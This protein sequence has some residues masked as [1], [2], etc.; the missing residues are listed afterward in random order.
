MQIF[1]MRAITFLLILLTFTPG[2]TFG[3]NPNTWTRRADIGYNAINGPTDPVITFSIG[4]KGYLGGKY[5]DPS[6]PYDFW[7]FDTSTNLWTQKAS[8]GGA[9]KS[10]IVGFS[11]GQKGY[12]VGSSYNS[13]MWE[14]TPLTNTWSR[15]ANFPGGL[16]HNPAAFVIMDKAYVGLG[17]FTNFSTQWPRDFWEYNPQTDTWA[18]IDSFAGDGRSNA[19]TFSIINRGYVGLGQKGATGLKDFWEYDPGT[20]RWVRIPDFPADVR[21]E[22]ASFGIATDTAGYIIG[23]RWYGAS[24]ADVW[25]YNRNTNSWIKKNDYPGNLGNMICFVVGNSPF[26]GLRDGS[27]DLWQY[28]TKSDTWKQK[29]GVGGIKRTGP[30]S[31]SINGKGYI[32]GGNPGTIYL[33]NDFWEYD[34]ETN[35]WTQKANFGGGKRS[36]TVAFSIGNKGYA[37][38][39]TQT[40]TMRDF[41]EYDPIT[42]I[43]TRKA[44]FGGGNREGATAFS[45][46]NKGYL[47]LGND[48]GLKNDFWEYDPST[49]VWTRKAD[50]PGVGRLGASGFSIAGKGYMGIGAANT[51]TGNPKDFWEYNPTTNTWTRK[52]DYI[53]RIAQ[54][55]SFAIGNKGYIGLGAGELDDHR[56]DLWEFDPTANTWTPKANFSGSGRNSAAAFV[57]GSKAYVAGGLSDIN[58]AEMDLWEYTSEYRIQISSINPNSYLCAGATI[59]IPFTV[60]GTFFQNNVFTAQLSD[61]NGSFANAVNI[62]N[63]TGAIGGIISATLPTNARSGN[64]YKIRILSSAP[65]IIGDAYSPVGI[66]IYGTLPVVN[67]TNNTGNKVCKNTAVKFTAS[68]T[69]LSSTTTFQWKKNNITVGANNN[70]YLDSTLVDSDTISCVVS[71]NN[72]CGTD[73]ATSNAIIMSVFSVSSKILQVDTSF[74]IG[75]TLALTAYPSEYHNYKWSKNHVLLEANTATFKQTTGGEYFCIV[76][77]MNNCFDTTSRI[78]LKT[79]IS[80]LVDVVAS[81]TFFCEKD[82]IFL[83]A[84][85]A[86][87]IVSYSWLDTTAISGAIRDTFITYAG[88]SF[89]VMVVDT[90]NCRGVSEPITVRMHAAPQIDITSADTSFCE[91]DSMILFVKN[92]VSGFSYKWSDTGIIPGAVHDSMIIH[93]GGKFSVVVIDTN[94][95]INSSEIKITMF[96]LPVPFISQSGDTLTTDTFYSYRWYRNNIAIPGAMY[97]TYVPDL[98][99]DYVVEVTDT[100]GCSNRSA[101][102]LV[103]VSIEKHFTSLPLIFPNPVH[104][105]IFIQSPYSFEIILCDLSGK[106]IRK[107]KNA[108]EMNLNGVANGVYIL[109]VR[110]VDQSILFT[111][112]ILKQE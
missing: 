42:N 32:G 40:F 50:F 85:V 41:W 101:S 111:N 49:N 33:Q 70:F 103:T 56:N 36:S 21:S 43:W 77:D 63:L 1:V 31:F 15:K 16:R 97:R 107:V 102:V 95:C 30:F 48:W 59:A 76:Y 35:V 109:H 53:G 58:G 100:N 18:Q 20:G 91:K 92:P 54:A 5:I 67:I 108:N 74:C 96:P 80:P 90:N 4:S 38:T 93:A 46:G 71:G 86:G 13:E 17:S 8:I 28:S 94:G 75:D 22:P 12:V 52:A 11:V 2:I 64:K 7:E 51:P 79:N 3:Q 84:Q 39:G 26:I 61:E 105:T 68:V 65:N 14:Y 19:A 55:T 98:D 57:I 81:D 29:I 10:G 62:G 47:G 25:K 78:T 69:G 82:S 6:I 73:L 89:Q 27:N 104:E 24:R 87:G 112:P 88:G 9:A 37:G 106:I 23:G 60:N 83:S 72:P 44:D 66:S 45:I 110:N 34:P 99:G